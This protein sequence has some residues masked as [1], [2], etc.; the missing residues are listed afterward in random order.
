V[1]M[2]AQNWNKECTPWTRLFFRVA[3]ADPL[4]QNYVYNLQKYN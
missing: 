1:G 4:A 3:D 2:G